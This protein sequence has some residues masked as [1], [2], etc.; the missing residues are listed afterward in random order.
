MDLI[1]PTVTLKVGDETF[2]SGGLRM[3]D[4]EDVL[5]T[6]SATGP[7]DV[8]TTIGQTTYKQRWSLADILTAARS[9]GC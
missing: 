2:V 5:K 3:S 6:L 8:T 9:I 1:P 4:L 7:A